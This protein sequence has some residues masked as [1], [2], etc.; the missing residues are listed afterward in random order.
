MTAQRH[1]STPLGRK[2][3]RRLSAYT[4][5]PDHILRAAIGSLERE[6][7]RAEQLQE[8]QA[9]VARHRAL[10]ALEAARAELKRRWPRA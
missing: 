5:M 4:L 10:A 3:A 7:D 9:S 2:S 1:D 8:P 6:I